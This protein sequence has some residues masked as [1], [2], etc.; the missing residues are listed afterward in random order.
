[1]PGARYFELAGYN[2]SRNCGKKLCFLTLCQQLAHLKGAESNTS[3]LLKAER[4]P[5]VDAR[6]PPPQVLTW[7]PA[8]RSK[9]RH[10]CVSRDRPPNSRLSKI[11][12]TLWLSR[13]INGFVAALNLCELTK[14]GSRLCVLYN[15]D[16]TKEVGDKIRT[17]YGVARKLLNLKKHELGANLQ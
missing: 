4:P 3:A 8:V 9:Q 6:H 5:I 2:T 10:T 7:R 16:C 13:L 14:P 1:M 12:G 15:Q 11:H 17:Q